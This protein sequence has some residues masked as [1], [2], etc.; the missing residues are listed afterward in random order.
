MP[1]S[2]ESAGKPDTRAACRA[3]MRAFSRKVPPVSGGES[4]PSALCAMSSRPSG[5]RIAFSS[6]SLPAL[7]LAR[8][9]FMSRTRPL[10]SSCALQ[11]LCLQRKQPL[12]AGGRQGEHGIELVPMKGMALGGTLQLDE[13][14]A[15]AHHHVHVGLGLRVL[16]IVQVQHRLP[17]YDTD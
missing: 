10:S 6:L 17:A 8:T 3:L 12:D 7:P 15:A 16:T 5:A 2:S 4:M 11:C 1:E 13:G 9:A 14:A